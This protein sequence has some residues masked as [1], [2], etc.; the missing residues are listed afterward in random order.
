MLWRG[1]STETQLYRVQESRARKQRS[2]EKLKAAVVLC[3]VCSSG[4]WLGKDRVSQRDIQGVIVLHQGCVLVVQDQ[5]LE[6]GVQVVGLC[7]PIASRRLVDH[8]VLGVTI[9]PAGEKRE[10]RLVA[11]KGSLLQQQEQST[12]WHHQSCSKI[13]L[14]LARGA[15]ADGRLW[16]SPACQLMPLPA[17]ASGK[18]R[19]EQHGSTANT[20]PI[21][22]HRPVLPTWLQPHTE[23]CG[24]THTTEQA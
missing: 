14:A 21:L 24:G 2:G 16:G 12:S 15:E 5:V 18:R 11:C 20:S 23:D 3:T 1:R 13:H 6:G 19:A 8:T 7:E 22:L 10:C 17:P 9:H 4:W